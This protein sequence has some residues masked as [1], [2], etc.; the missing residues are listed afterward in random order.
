MTLPLSLASWSKQPLKGITIPMFA[1]SGYQTWILLIH[2]EFSIDY[3]DDDLL[4]V[5]LKMQGSINENL[6]VMR[7]MVSLSVKDICG[8]NRETRH[9]L[10]EKDNY[11]ILEIHWNRYAY[12]QKDFVKHISQ[13]CMVLLCQPIKNIIAQRDDGIYQ[14]YRKILPLVVKQLRTICQS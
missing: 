5:T 6:G 2:T 3:T 13:L 12:C 1:D 7:I 11:S 9:I 10:F 8:W 4:H 14:I